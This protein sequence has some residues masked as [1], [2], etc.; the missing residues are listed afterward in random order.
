MVWMSPGNESTPVGQLA[1]G[2]PVRHDAPPHRS[3]LRAHRRRRRRRAGLV[4]F[5][6]V[7]AGLGLSLALAPVD[8]GPSIDPA[9]VAD[10]LIAIAGG[11]IVLISIVFSL[12]FVVVQFGSTV[13]TPRL[14]LFRDNPLVWHA[15][16]LFVGTFIFTATTSLVISRDA[17]VSVVVPAVTITLTMVCLGVARALQLSAFR[18]IQLSPTLDDIAARGHA[19]LDALYTERF[20]SRTAPVRS[21]PPVRDALRWS[22]REAILCQI[23]L[24]K[25]VGVA[26][27]IDGVIE[28]RVAVG[29]V[30]RNG[31]TIMVTRGGTAQVQPDALLPLLEAGL[32]R[33]FGQDPLFAFR[34]LADIGLR[35]LSPA[36]NDPTTAVQV[37]DAVE[38]LLCSVAGRNL[39]VGEI[40]G[41]DAQV[42][43]LLSTPTWETYVAHGV[44]ELAYAAREAPLVARRLL[45]L[46][47]DVE[48]AAPQS[49]RRPLHAR[50]RWIEANCELLPELAGDPH[51]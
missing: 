26:E 1:S 10:L 9:R 46:L 30:L 48:E 20:P 17:D 39:D 45:E 36:V 27:K 25:L 18:S 34:L 22:R 12:L 40:G 4:Q 2:S 13:L 24:P 49:R 3:V 33:T 37:L 29:D 28:L 42:R 6:Y 8:L 50:R 7:L 21:L 11:L 32:E 35:A 43:V 47:A 5:L 38:G 16:G 41:A 44:D 23:D 19:V 15:F 51:P 14:N 31:A